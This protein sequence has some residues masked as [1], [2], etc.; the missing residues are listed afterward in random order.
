MILIGN[1]KL[2][3]LERHLYHAG[4]WRGPPCPIWGS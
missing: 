2:R 4:V 3:S 1:T